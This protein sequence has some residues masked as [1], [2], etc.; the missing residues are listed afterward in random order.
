[1]IFTQAEG[2][3]VV[4]FMVVVLLLLG[5]LGGRLS[6]LQRNLGPLHRVEA[7]VDLLLKQ[8]GIKFD[9]YAS[10]SLDIA[11]AVRRGEKIKAIKLY[12]EKTGVGLREAKEYIEILQQ[13]C[14]K[15]VGSHSLSRC[16]RP[17]EGIIEC[18]SAVLI[19]GTARGIDRTRSRSLAFW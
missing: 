15:E 2:F 6:A 4:A 13:R 17:S 3:V 19:V 16:D 1:V 8:A 7:K 11:E 18:V 10:V 12:R 14:N 9:P 5:M